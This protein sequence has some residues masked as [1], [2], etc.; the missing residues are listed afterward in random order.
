MVIQIQNLT[1]HYGSV[2]GIDDL[3]LTVERGEIFGFLGP[4][5]AGKTTTIRLLLDLITPTA[6]LIRLFGEKPDRRQAGIRNRVGYLPGDFRPDPNMSGQ[7]FLDYHARFRTRPAVKRGE[8]LDR[9]AFPT[10]RLPH[11][12]KHLSHGNRQKLGI[13]HALEHDPEIVILDEP[14]LGLDPLIQ[15]A[16]YHMLQEVRD[17]QRTVFFSSHNLAEVEKLCQRVAIIRAGH[18]VA[19]DTIE[20]MRHSRPRRLVLHLPESTG[21]GDIRLDGA[22]LLSVTSTRMTFLVE[23]DV[24][25]VLAQ[26]LRLPVLDIF[27][28]E[29]DLE[30]IFLAYYADEATIHD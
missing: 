7:Y 23:G 21:P 30:D 11:K 29:P 18:L 25:P 16:L 1:K 20:S 13:I 24:R 4:N 22:R 9:L 19:L 15:D 8:L 3:S 14:T 27:L 5:G 26:V 12:I 28:P 6:G 10:D 2:V 17:H